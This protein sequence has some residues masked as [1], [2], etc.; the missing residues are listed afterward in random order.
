MNR[1]AMD[2]L[3][4]DVVGEALADFATTRPAK[5]AQPDNGLV[6]LKAQ[7][8]SL[9]ARLE[10]LAKTAE[11]G[12]H[13]VLDDVDEVRKQAIAHDHKL[14]ALEEAICPRVAAR[15]QSLERH[16]ARQQDLNNIQGEINDTVCQRLNVQD[17]ASE[18]K[19]EPAQPAKRDLDPV[20]VSHG[21]AYNKLEANIARR[22]REYTEISTFTIYLPLARDLIKAI[23]A[24]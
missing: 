11:R 9:E 18:Y 3:M 15:L 22:I 7:M 21:V 12:D 17:S 20:I 8:R 2:R 1:N 13:I 4:N 14:K 16:V 5:P 6:E 19:A 24:T 10:L 23:Q